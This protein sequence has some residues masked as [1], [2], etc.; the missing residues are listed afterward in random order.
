MEVK[1]TDRAPSLSRL[2]DMGTTRAG[3][4]VLNP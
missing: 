2:T 1:K 3:A 4:A